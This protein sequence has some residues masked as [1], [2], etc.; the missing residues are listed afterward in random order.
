MEWSDQASDQ[1]VVDVRGDSDL[2]E[3]VGVL[4]AVHRADGYPVNWPADPAGW[5]RVDG[6]LGAWVARLGGRIAGHVVLARPAPGDV[7]PR[8]APPGGPTAVVGRLFVAPGARG[9]RIGAQLL[10]RAAREARRSG[11]RAVLDVVSRDVSAVALYERS[12]WTFLGAGQQ[13]WGPGELV[14]VRCYAA[15][16]KSEESP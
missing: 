16:P 1:A 13:E 15:A 4:G 3:C 5:L 2:A 10:G 14:D 12:G 6:E 9:R 8:L 7:A 11:A